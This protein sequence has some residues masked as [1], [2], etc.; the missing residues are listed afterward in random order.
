MFIPTPAK[1]SGVQSQGPRGATIAIV[2]DYPSAYDMRSLRPFSGPEGNI[3]EQ[4]LHNVG[5]IRGELYITHLFKDQSANALYGKGRFTPEGEATVAA[6]KV[7]LNET[8]AN[9]ILVMGE[10]A[11]CALSG[12][13]YL[14]RYRGYL[15]PTTEGVNAQKCIGTIHPRDAS[16][17]L[18][19]NRYLIVA[20]L[21]KAISEQHTKELTRPERTLI[22]HYESVNEALEWLAYFNEQP[23]V[24]VDIEV[25]NYEVSCIGFSSAPNLACVIPISGSWSAEDEFLLWRAIAQVLGNGAKKVFQNGIFDIQFLLAK[26]NIVVRGPILDT[27]IAHSVMYPDLPKNLGFLG[28]IYCGA[29][30]YWKDTVKFSNIKGES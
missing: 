14:S 17:G 24:S 19:K 23:I 25:L 27:M 30:E 4:C 16:F 2:A 18:Y 3:L 11:F 22:Y 13:P 12:T 28:S 20:D 29:Q 9:I 21:K 7:E 6:L 8:G 1:P 26:N 15:F 10:S 5:L